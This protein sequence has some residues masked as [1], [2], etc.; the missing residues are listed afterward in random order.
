MLCL[1][2]KASIRKAS[3]LVKCH[4][5]L[6]VDAALEPFAVRSGPDQQITNVSDGKESACNGG[7]SRFDPRVGKIPWRREW[8]RTP[9][10]L[11]G[12]SHGQRS[13]TGDSPWGHKESHATER[14]H[15]S[16][17]RTGEGSGNPLQCSRLENPRDGGAWW[18]AVYGVAQ[19]R[20]RLKRLSS[21]SM[22]TSY[23][24]YLT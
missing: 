20:T 9:V 22:V 3:R 15:F 23:D 10:F 2:N 1:L 5:S 14:L 19:S 12:E 4:G 13:L 17:S 21:S 8:L 16:L 18:A 6:R 7:R 11:P 24:K